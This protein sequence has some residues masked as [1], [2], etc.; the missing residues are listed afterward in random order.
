MTGSVR[1]LPFTLTNGQVRIDRMAVPAGAY[2]VELF[3][4][5]GELLGYGRVLFAGD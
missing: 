1:S 4:D 2:L 5:N 3:S